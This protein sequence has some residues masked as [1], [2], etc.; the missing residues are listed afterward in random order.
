MITEIAG[1]DGLKFF[2]LR[3]TLDKGPGTKSPGTNLKQIGSFLILKET[4]FFWGTMSVS[5]GLGPIGGSNIKNVWLTI[6]RIRLTFDFF[7]FIYF[8]FVF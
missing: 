2:F 8:S 3:V 6:E 5:K 4:L 7:L 1:F